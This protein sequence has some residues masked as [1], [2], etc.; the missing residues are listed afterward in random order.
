MKVYIVYGEAECDGCDS[1]VVHKVFSTQEKAVAYRSE[2]N[3]RKGWR[4]IT[5]IDEIELE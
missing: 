4:F 3:V 1:D 2:M 5:R